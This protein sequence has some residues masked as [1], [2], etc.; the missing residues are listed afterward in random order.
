LRTIANHP[1]ADFKL[2]HQINDALVNALPV[3]R[4]W[5]TR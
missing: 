1:N 5:S 2:T 3:T 4:N